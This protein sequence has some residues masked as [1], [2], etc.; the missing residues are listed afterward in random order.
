LFPNIF[1]FKIFGKW[2]IEYDKFFHG[3]KI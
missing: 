2:I 3:Q 1:D